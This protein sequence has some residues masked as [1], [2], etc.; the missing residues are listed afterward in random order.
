MFDT[1]GMIGKLKEFQSKMKES[2][3][4][5]GQITES[6]E[7]GAGM[8]KATVNGHKRVISLEIDPDLLKAEDREMVQDLVVAAINRAIESIEDKI[9]DHLQKST[10][11]LMSG[12]PNIPGLDLS[13]LMK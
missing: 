8:V 3:E 13:K 12:L 5:L 4:S 6:A 10:E 9:K 11:G 2:Q 7:A 1:L